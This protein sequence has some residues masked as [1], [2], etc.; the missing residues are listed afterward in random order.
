MRRSIGL[1]LPA[2]LAL[3]L[4]AAPAAAADE[5]AVS[6]DEVTVLAVGEPT[7]P[8]PK[9]RLAEDN[10]ARELAGYEDREIPPTWGGAWILLFLGVVGLAALLG[11]YYLLVHRPAQEA[12]GRR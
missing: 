2:L 8:M 3:V 1:L 5:A 9:D 7:G 4:L 6:V 10:P 11:L 12:A